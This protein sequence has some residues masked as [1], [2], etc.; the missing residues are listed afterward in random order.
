MKRIII[1]LVAIGCIGIIL[2]VCLDTH[3]REHFGGGCM[4]LIPFSHIKKYPVKQN[5]IF[6]SIASYRDRKCKK[7]IHSLFANA[8][9]PLSVF[10]GVCEQN[11]VKKE[12]C[13][14]CPQYDSQIRFK[15]LSY[16]EAKG[17]TFARYWCSL[18]WK[19]EELYLQ[20]DSHMKF[21]P[22]W[23]VKCFKMV[24][25]ASQRGN[26]RV[27]ISAYPP[28]PSQMNVKGVPAICSAKYKQ[29]LPSFVASWS[30]PSTAPVPSPKPFVAAGLMLL[31][32]SFLYSVPFDP[33]LPH[34]F[35]GEEILLS[36]R[37]WT[38]GYDMYTPNHKIC[39]HDYGRKGEPKV[40]EDH[41][42]SECRARAVK[43]AQ[44]ILG[45]VSKK[46]IL[47]DFLIETT[48][49]GLGRERTIEAFWKKA[50]IDPVSKTVTSGCA[51]LYKTRR[52]KNS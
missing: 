49:Y 7:T 51:G 34:L 19:G 6:V 33:Y 46:S 40:W 48:L 27:V 10:V 18:L 17:P 11:K 30:L 37:L 20:I 12:G 2:A 24:R 31:P 38:H 25:Q 1:G 9:S 39:S 4:D 22:G 41:N 23:D 21:V 50:G 8:A 15:R 36:A 42:E 52:R 28:T 44:F 26:P 29:T 16:K 43:R 32:G 45:L 5:C 47:P 3:L 35:Q 13:G 14:C